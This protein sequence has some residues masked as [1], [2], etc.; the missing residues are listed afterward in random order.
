MLKA[1]LNQSWAIW[2]SFEQRDH[3]HPLDKWIIL[4]L[5]SLKQFHH[6]HQYFKNNANSEQTAL[7]HAFSLSSKT[8]RP[9]TADRR[10][11]M[12][13]KTP[14]YRQS[15]RFLHLIWQVGEWQLLID[16][17]LRLI[18]HMLT[19]FLNQ[20]SKDD[21]QKYCVKLRKLGII[22]IWEVTAHYQLEHE[23]LNLSDFLIVNL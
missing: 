12:S 1:W 20:A 3:T 14:G 5:K 11:Y 22:I 10:K 23:T 15:S 19:D 21:F 6:N 13:F 16:D 9:K 7:L 17:P 4:F 8:T 2:S 18:T